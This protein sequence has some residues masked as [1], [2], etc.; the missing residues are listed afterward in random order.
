[1]RIFVPME[2]FDIAIALLTLIALEVVLGIDNIIFI[3]ILSDK[4]PEGQRDKLRKWGIGLAM[5]MRLGLLTAI[6]WVMTLDTDLFTVWGQVFSGKELILLVG[7]VFLLYKATRE[8][9]H[10][11]EKLKDDGKK[12]TGAHT[13][14]SLLAQVLVLDLV[15]S[16]DSIITAVGMVDE[17]WVM[18]VAVV[19]TVGIMLLASQPIINFI[20]K[21]PSFKVL[22]LS[23]LMVIGVALVAEGMGHYLPKGYIYGPMAFAFFVD[24]LQMRVLGAKKA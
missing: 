19:V 23:F 18:Y 4:L 5:V 17:L 7:G 16:L 2:V 1:M 12:D 3:G 15:F 9:F 20:S 11:T 10:M 24:V 22:A 6:S 13:F 8:I 21:H 14:G